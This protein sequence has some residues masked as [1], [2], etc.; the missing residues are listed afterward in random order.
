VARM[1][2]A[3]L[4]ECP[5]VNGD[6]RQI[7]ADAKQK[8]PPANFTWSERLVPAQNGGKWDV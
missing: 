7:D 1:T 4:A 6:G 2:A 8:A 3:A 5:E